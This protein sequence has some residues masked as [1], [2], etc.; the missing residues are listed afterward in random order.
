MRS[1]TLLPRPTTKRRP[2]PKTAVQKQPF[3]A[4]AHPAAL[5]RLSTVQ[6]LTGLGR[7]SIYDKARTGTFPQPVKIGTRCTRWRAGAVMAWLKAPQ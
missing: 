7:S 6:A 5:L 2:L 3:E 1:T 4:A